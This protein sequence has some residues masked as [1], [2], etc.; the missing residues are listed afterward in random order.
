MVFRRKHR[1][2]PEINV[3]SLIDVVLQLLIFFMLSSSFITQP[4]IRIDLPNAKATTKNSARENNT[5]MITADSSIYINKEKMGNIDDLQ[6]QLKKLKQTQ[7]DN[8]V[9]IIKADAQVAHGIV[10]SVMDVARTSG[11]GRIAIATR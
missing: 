10:V 5:I 7:Q 3:T 2:R 6:R 4:G 9:I 11:F 8:E 1:A